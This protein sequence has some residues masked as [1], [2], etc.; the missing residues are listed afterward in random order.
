MIKTLMNLISEVVTR[1]VIAL[2]LKMNLA[3]RF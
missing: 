3:P 1:G 2:S